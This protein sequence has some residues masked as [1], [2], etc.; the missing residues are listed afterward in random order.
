MRLYTQLTPER[1]LGVVLKMRIFPHD[2]LGSINTAHFNFIIK[3]HMLWWVWRII[4]VAFIEPWIQEISSSLQ[5]GFFS[6]KKKYCKFPTF[7]L[8]DTAT[9][10]S[11]ISCDQCW[12]KICLSPA[13]TISK[14]SSTKKIIII[15]AK[16]NT[17]TKAKSQ[18]PL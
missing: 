12:S 7:K 5:F 11:E 18:N 3:N 1:K 4:Y 15:K 16:K 6:Y 8:E 2:D 9:L 10:P 13:E 17:T 14:I